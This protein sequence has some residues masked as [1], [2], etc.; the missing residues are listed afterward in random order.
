MFNIDTTT[1]LPYMQEWYETYEFCPEPYIKLGKLRSE[2]LTKLVNEIHFDKFQ[3]LSNL[4][5]KDYSGYGL[6]THDGSIEGWET[7]TNSNNS[8]TNNYVGFIK[9]VQNINPTSCNLDSPET[10]KFLENFLNLKRSHYANMGPNFKFRVHADNPYQEGIRFQIN[11]TGSEGTTYIFNGTEFNI[12][13]GEI[14]WLNTGVPHTVMNFSTTN[15]INLLIDV[16]F[17]Q[18]LQAEISMI[19]HN[20]EKNYLLEA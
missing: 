13:D 20:L 9:S 5:H 15:R 11:L 4:S 16:S 6:I 17:Q 2:V 12:Q 14:F 18:D 8:Y 19:K 1:W 10:Y 7:R 3:R